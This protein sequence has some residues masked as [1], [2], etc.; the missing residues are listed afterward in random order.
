[1]SLEAFL[2]STKATVQEN[3][4]SILAALAVGGVA[5]TGYV[6]YQVGFNTASDIRDAEDSAGELMTAKEKV[7]RYWKR[8][9]PIFILGVTAATCVIASTAINNRRN[10]LL[11]GTLAITETAYREYRDKV[12]KV[13]SKPK[14][15]Q[16]DKELAEDK[17]ER[18]EGSEIVFVGDGKVL[19]FD[20]LTSRYFES[21]KLDVERAEVEINRRLLSDMYVSQNEWYDAI[22]LP[23]TSMG[24]DVGWNHDIPLEVKFIP[25]IKDDKPVM[26]IDYRFQPSIGFSRF[27]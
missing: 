19:C 18:A 17:L 16:V 23:R 27:H 24:D 25:L 3:S 6:A 12:E 5:T 14:R 9:I 22:G 2:K 4:P 11:G 8:H 7:E 13:V 15:E 1:M 26:G 20:T 10:A 21:S